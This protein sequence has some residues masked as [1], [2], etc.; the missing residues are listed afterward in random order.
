MPRMTPAH[1]RTA[2]ASQEASLSAP[3]GDQAMTGLAGHLRRRPFRKGTRKGTMIF[4]ED[5]APRSPAPRPSKT[6]SH[7]C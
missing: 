7:M 5:Q 4:H 6:W 1:D 3:L 2:T